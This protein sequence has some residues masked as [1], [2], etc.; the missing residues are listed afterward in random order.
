MNIS[1]PSSST[2]YIYA[3]LE[4]PADV[5]LGTHTVDVA[6]VP[7]GQDVKVGDWRQ[8]EWALDATDTVRFLVGPAGDYKLA[9]GLYSVYV[10]VNTPT[11]KPVRKA[12]GLRVVATN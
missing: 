3:P 7:R 9:V 6:V 10:R 8:A 12:G 5:E 11:E 2:E 4:A 1:I